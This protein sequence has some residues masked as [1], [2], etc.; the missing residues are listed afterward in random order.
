MTQTKPPS[1]SQKSTSRAPADRKSTRLNS[2]HL[3]ISYAVFRSKKKRGKNGTEGRKSKR[4]TTYTRHL[5]PPDQ[6]CGI[7][8]ALHGEDKS[9][10]DAD[11]DPARSPRYAPGSS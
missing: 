9:D 6:Q 7:N 3:V 11:T 10:H 1:R 2:S 8:L 4:I 5:M